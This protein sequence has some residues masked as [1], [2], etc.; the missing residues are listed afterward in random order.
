MRT[1]ET[2]PRMLL[3]IFGTLASAAVLAACGTDLGGGL[4][5]GSVTGYE[6]ANALSPTGHHVADLGGGRYRI[7]ATGSALTPK[8]RVE[9]IGMARAA[10]FGI[11]QKQKFFQAS[12][13]QHSI[14]C[15]KRDYIERGVKKQL[16]N[17]GYSVVEIDVIY[18]NTATDPSFRPVKDTA[19]ALMAELR[20]EV[21]PEEAR[22]EPEREIK[23]QCGA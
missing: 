17:R 12:A 13:L 19:E 14:R 5:S 18:A 1:T 2:R 7:T 16:P 20:S 11:E 15:G 10:E 21:V 4:Q 9:K 3:C 6:A 23:A 22:I 8:A